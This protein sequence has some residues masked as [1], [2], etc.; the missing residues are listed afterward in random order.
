M[1]IPELSKNQ[2]TLI[3]LIS[4]AVLIVIILLAVYW[5][6]IKTRINEIKAD[7]EIKKEIDKSELTLSEV[8]IEALA[9]KLYQAMDGPGTD[10]G[11]IYSVFEQINN[12]SELMMLIRAFGQ[13]KSSWELFWGSP[14]GLADW[15][16]ADLDG[17]EINHLN[18][19]LAG[20]NIDFK[21]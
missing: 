13:R 3:G 18:S 11:K 4:A 5:N 6:K 20:K 10:E 9:D 14:T 1:Q 12:Y 7:N 16:N 8:Q 15:L 17:G 21:F 19:I 2:L